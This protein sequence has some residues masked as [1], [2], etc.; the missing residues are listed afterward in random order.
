MHSCPLHVLHIVDAELIEGNDV[1]YQGELH[2][3]WQSRCSAAATW[4]CLK[5][6]SHNADQYGPGKGAYHSQES[7]LT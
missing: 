3:T 2:C 1:L 4:L 6:I 5:E 7:F